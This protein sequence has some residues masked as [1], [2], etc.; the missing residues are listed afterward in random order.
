MQGHSHQLRQWRVLDSNTDF[1]DE[2]GVQTLFSP[3]E[4]R[5]TEVLGYDGADNPL[6]GEWKDHYGDYDNLSNKPTIDQLL[7]NL[8]T[9]GF[10]KRTGTNNYVIDT[11]NYQPLDADLSSI[12]GLSGTS[13]L[14][15]KTAS[16]TWQLDTS[17]YLTAL[18]S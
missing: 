3:V 4:G 1:G 11:S 8:S 9:L 7:G 2:N 14:L 18:P 17:V 15:R 6:W 12:A 10:V 13:G 5:Y 16:N